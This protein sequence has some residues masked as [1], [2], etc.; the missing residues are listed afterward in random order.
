MGADGVELDVRLAASRDGRN[1]LVAFHDPLPREQSML[2]ALPGF[3]EVLEACGDRMLINVEIKNSVDDGGF[4]PT[5]AVAAPVIDAMRRFD[6][7]PDRF[8][9]SSFSAKTVDHCR[10]IEPSIATALLCEALDE[11]A[12]RRA[13]Q[14][15]HRAIHPSVVELTAA[16]VA[17]AH[18]AGLA[19]NAWTCN[20]PQRLVELAAM[21]V[22][23]VCTDVPDVARTALGRVAG[24]AASPRWALRP[25]H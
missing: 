25:A 24:D 8:V 3:A 11:R 7:S 21:G 5:M 15:G 12:I 4:D 14:G 6:A 10:L 19:V 23:G 2:D 18:D 22:D 16:S 20:D 9:I 1:R 13:L 17:A